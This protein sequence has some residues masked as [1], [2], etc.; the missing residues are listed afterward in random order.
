MDLVFLQLLAVPQFLEYPEHLCH[1]VVHRVLWAP[2]RLLVRAFQ[3][4]QEVP[5]LQETLVIQ[6]VRVDLVGLVVLEVPKAPPYHF[7]LVCRSL[8][9]FPEDQEVRALQAVRFHQLVWQI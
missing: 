5:S 8:L 2:S 3:G 7:R 6:R 1:P 9:V 4:G